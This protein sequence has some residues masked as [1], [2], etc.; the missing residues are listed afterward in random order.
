MRMLLKLMTTFYVSVMSVASGGNTVVEQSPHHYKVMG[1]SLAM[2]TGTGREK[3]TKNLKE[4]NH[5]GNAQL[6]SAN[7]TQGG[8]I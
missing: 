4:T 5:I 8:S 1:L 6:C 3:M 2:A 7:I